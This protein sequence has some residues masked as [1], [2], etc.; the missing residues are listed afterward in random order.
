MNVCNAE[1]CSVSRKKKK[2]NY[3]LAK[4][5]KNSPPPSNK[6]TL[7]LIKGIDLQDT[8][9]RQQSYLLFW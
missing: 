7:L 5:K 4:K 2:P 6:I 1:H 8:L 9:F 3:L